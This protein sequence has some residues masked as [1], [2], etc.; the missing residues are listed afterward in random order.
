MAYMCHEFKKVLRAFGEYFAP[1]AQHLFGERAAP[2]AVWL[3]SSALL[4]AILHVWR[5][6]GRQGQSTRLP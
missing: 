2:L 5:K 3:A 1:G 6:S 4:V